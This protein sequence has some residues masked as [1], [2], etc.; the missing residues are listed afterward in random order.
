[1]MPRAWRNLLAAV[2][3]AASTVAA[4]HKGSDSYLT[5]DFAGDA[6]QGR[7]DI[8]LADLDYVL[9]LDAD[10]DGAITWGEVRVREADISAYALRSLA[11]RADGA[12]CAP[13]VQRL[14][15]DAHSDGAYAVLRLAGDCP[16][17]AQV[18]V[19]YSL[20]FDA[21]ARH[22]GIARLDLGGEVRG[23]I[24]SPAQSSQAFSR[25]DAPAWLTLRRFGADG[26]RH[27]LTGWDHLLFLL[28]LLLPVMLV[29]EGRR[30]TGISPPRRALR[31]IIGLVTAFTLAHSVTLTLA[32]LQWIALPSRWVET[33][34]AASVLLAAIDNLVPILPRRRWL[35]AFAFG[36]VHGLGFASVLVDLALPPAKLAISLVGFNLGVEVG[37][38]A[39]V[40][41]V[42]PVLFALRAR[43]LYPRIAV[44]ALSAVIAVL[45][46]GWLIE[47]AFLITLLPA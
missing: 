45:A 28:A 2:L 22:R 23:A 18:H 41:L 20:L 37:Q 29:R 35:V 21:D 33:A 34:I 7:W 5:L 9:H 40:A 25:A 17:A 4:A 3:L 46:L 12:R 27:I 13:T 1:M 36:L 43:R 8:A 38:L 11:V 31:D 42:V 19:D 14:E 32:T 39:A 16:R 15:I 6:V 44:G 30:W 10:G 47:R 26:V 24:F